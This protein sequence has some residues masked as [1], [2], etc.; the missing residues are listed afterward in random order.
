MLDAHTDAFDHGILL[1][2]VG[3]VACLE[4]GTEEFAE[5]LP[6]SGSEGSQE[7][8]DDAVAGLVGLAVDELDEQFALALG[9]LV[10][11]GLVLLEELFLKLLEVG[12]LLLLGLVGIDVLIGL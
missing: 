7:G 9:H 6:E 1:V 2:L 11:L 3:V 8:L 5:G 12:L 10:H 4:T